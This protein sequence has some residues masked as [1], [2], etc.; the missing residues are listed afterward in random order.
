ME[1]KNNKA[2]G[3]E[4]HIKEYR[5]DDLIVYWDAKACSH[6]GN[7]WHTLPE[8]FRQDER[9]WIVMKEST[10]EKIIAAV[11]KCPTD[12]LKYKLPE[13]SKVDPELAKGPGSVDYKKDE[14]TSIKIKM[15]KSGPYKVE[16]TAQVF[17]SEGNLLKQS[18][19][20]ILCGCGKSGNRPFCDGSHARKE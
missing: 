17:D 2:D 15:A 5:T 1:S 14:I 6:I 11:D 12:A 13:G 10:P 19:R 20:I 9:P 7:C 3:K 18:S 16:G 8:V 4:N